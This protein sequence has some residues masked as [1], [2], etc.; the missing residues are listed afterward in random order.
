MHALVASLLIITTILGN[1]S[2]IDFP[3]TITSAWEETVFGIKYEK[4]TLVEAVE[5]FIGKLE[6]E[7][8]DEQFLKRVNAECK[9][10]V[11]GIYIEY[12]PNGQIKTRLPYKNHLPNGHLHGWYDHGGDAFKGHFKMGVK[13]GAHIVFCH[14]K[15]KFDINNKITTL[16]YNLKGILEGEQIYETQQPQLLLYTQYINGKLHGPLKTWL[17][18]NDQQSYH[19]ALY[20]NGLL[21]NEPPPE[22]SNREVVP[23]PYSKLANQIKAQFAR[24]VQKE[25]G[26]RAC[27]VGGSMPYDVENII[28]G[29]V[30]YKRTEKDEARAL[31]IELSSL[32]SS[33]IN[34]HEEIRPYLREYP[35]PPTRAWVTISFEDKKTKD[36]YR[37][38]SIGSV[39]IGRDGD[40]FYYSNDPNDPK[41]KIEE[42]EPYAEA[43]KIVL[44]QQKLSHE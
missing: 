38:G 8:F 33:M 1:T 40:V 16:N 11:S 29:F 2:S 35:F 4:P 19:G 7:D 39:S 26:F 17:R 44:Q 23:C 37:D 13:Q 3:K 14:G 9:K 6:K 15:S 42:R 41:K 30:S 10:N 36:R 12:W 31:F 18:D 21:Q 20:K 28:M 25:Y 5:E 27:S 43:E 22:R 24:A 32:L 34:D